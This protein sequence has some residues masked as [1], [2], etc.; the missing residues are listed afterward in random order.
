MVEQSVRSL[1]AEN[2]RL[3]E[4]ATDLEAANETIEAL[5]KKETTLKSDLAYNK[6][7]LQEALTT[8]EELEKR[9]TGPPADG[10]S[11]LAGLNDMEIVIDE[12]K[13]KMRVIVTKRRQEGDTALGPVEK[14][15]LN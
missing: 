15:I 9:P 11:V 6:N 14:F 5:R 8:I 3:Q 2:E 4:A 12:D 13:G 10:S 7:A 1:K